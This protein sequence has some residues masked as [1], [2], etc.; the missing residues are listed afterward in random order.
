SHRLASLATDVHLPGDVQ[1]LGERLRLDSQFDGDAIRLIQD[2]ARAARR[3][4]ADAGEG[5]LPEA[6]EDKARNLKSPRAFTFRSHEAEGA[7]D[8]PQGEHGSRVAASSRRHRSLVADDSAKSVLAPVMR[9][10]S[11]NPPILPVE[12]AAYLA[13]ASL[14]TPVLRAV[15][16]STDQ[17]KKLR[18]RSLFFRG[19]RNRAKCFAY[20]EKRGPKVGMRVFLTDRFCGFGEGT[21]QSFSLR[22]VAIETGHELLSAAV[23]H[24]PKG[25]KQGAS[26]SIECAAGKAN[27]LIA[28]GNGTE[29]GAA[30]A[31]REKV[32]GE[33]EVEEFVEVKVAVTKTNRGKHRIVRA[34]G[35]VSGDVDDAFLRSL[36]KKQL[37]IGGGAKVKLASGKNAMQGFNFRLDERSAEIRDAQDQR[38]GAFGTAGRL[39]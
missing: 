29:A 19:R 15:N 34:V 4:G 26:A 13:L 31:E 17:P 35:A 9:F 2:L 18:R 21:G 3:G 38:S 12:S 24:I 10:R 36:A 8:I 6:V 33:L 32:G 23:V 16:R 25:E 1:A 22:A 27:K 28:F 39:R 14:S 37:V 20:K 7:S 5:R 11:R 30:T